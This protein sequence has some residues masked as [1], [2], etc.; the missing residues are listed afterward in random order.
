M[1]G[2]E[3]LQ[4]GALS[5]LQIRICLVF[6]GNIPA[7]TLSLVV[8][9]FNDAVGAAARY[10]H[11]GF[12]ECP[13][14]GTFRFKFNYV[15]LEVGSRVYVRESHAERMPGRAG[16]DQAGRRGCSQRAYSSNECAFAF[17]FRLHPIKIT[18]LMRS[19]QHLAISSRLSMRF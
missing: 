2:I 6:R 8:R 16:C 12:Y 11:L 18:Y 14:L 17:A 7:A 19:T 5:H 10:D 1:N 4:L 9:N 3:A 15:Q 13:L